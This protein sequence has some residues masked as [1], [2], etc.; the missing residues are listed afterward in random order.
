VGSEWEGKG[1]LCNS[2]VIY[3]QMLVMILYY[4][5]TDVAMGE[6]G[7]VKSTQFLSVLSHVCMKL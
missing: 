7:W 6:E 1:C 2:T 4:S 3:G 5:S